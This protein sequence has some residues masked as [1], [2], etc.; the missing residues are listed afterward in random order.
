[1][2]TKVGL[3]YVKTKIFL[4]HDV[5]LCIFLVSRL[6]MYLIHFVLFLNIL[7]HTIYALFFTPE[8]QIISQKL[9]HFLRHGTVT[10]PLYLL[11]GC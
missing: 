7:L 2:I 5:F 4:V 1:M 9:H 11:F 10:V 6:H 3:L 8:L